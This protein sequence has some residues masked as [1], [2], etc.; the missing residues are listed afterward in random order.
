MTAIH[1]SETAPPRFWEPVTFKAGDRVRV[2]LS[3]ECR[4]PIWPKSW[5]A[6]N[7]EQWMHSSFGESYANGLTGVVAD[8]FDQ[9]PFIDEELIAEAVAYYVEHGHPYDVIFD[10]PI[11]FQ[12]IVNHGGM[13]AAVELELLEASS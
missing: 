3:G 7:G 2:R 4:V 5:G 13:F 8:P 11:F 9:Y 12:N 10:E 6:S 1:D